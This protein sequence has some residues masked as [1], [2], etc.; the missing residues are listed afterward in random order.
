MYN[1][2][3]EVAEVNSKQFLLGIVLNF[4]ITH[5]EPILLKA[6]VAIILT[7][8]LGESLY[9]RHIKGFNIQTQI[10]EDQ[11]IFELYD[12]KMYLEGL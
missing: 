9:H 3:R 7:D 4:P 2:W 6:I 10:P 12:L 11:E 8:T 1:C 5:I